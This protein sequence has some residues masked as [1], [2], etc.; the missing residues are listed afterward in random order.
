M[1]D[2]AAKCQL[3]EVGS[4]GRSSPLA[5]RTTPAFSSPASHS[6]QLP[7]GDGG[8]LLLALPEPSC[9]GVGGLALC[10]RRLSESCMS[11]E[12]LPSP[13]SICSPYPLGH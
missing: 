6:S 9:C 5:S 11:A 4:G 13:L 3:R 10:Y 1:Q 7:A 12:C 2:S 8:G